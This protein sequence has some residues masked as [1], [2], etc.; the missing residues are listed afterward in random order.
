[1][2]GPS[3]AEPGDLRFEKGRGYMNRSAPRRRRGRL[4]RESAGKDGAMLQERVE[5]KWIETFAAVF[6]RCD[7]KTGEEVAVVSE[8]QSRPVN[9]HLAELAL[10]TL[11]ARPFHVVVPSPPQRA[12]VPV[13][14]TR[15]SAAP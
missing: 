2:S 8:T 15:A 3:A 7:V 6:R 10:A 9:I 13:R 14:S 1:M 4:P 5:G 11:G 12:G